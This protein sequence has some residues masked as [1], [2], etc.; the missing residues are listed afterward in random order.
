MSWRFTEAQTD[1]LSCVALLWSTSLDGEVTDPNPSWERFTGQS[2][3]GY[4]GSGWLDAVH[5]E[6]RDATMDA[7]RRSVHSRERLTTSYRLRRRDGEYRLMAVVG[8][9]VEEGGVPS[10]WI[11]SCQDMT[12]AHR[13][14]QAL[15]RSEE[16]FRFLDELGQ[17]TRTCA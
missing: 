9:L 10:G 1:A 6:D 2:L 5:P 11:G 12:E 8:T 17:A 14:E 3:Q 7:W 4:S 15:Q 13:N 16:R